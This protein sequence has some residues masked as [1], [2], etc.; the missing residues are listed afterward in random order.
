MKN[1][2]FGLLALLLISGA[3]FWYLSDQRT[4]AGAS[5]ET[6]GSYA[7][8]CA[9]G[10]SFL[11]TPSAD[12]QRIGI[13]PRGN[14]SFAAQTLRAESS[15]R[16]S[17]GSTVLSGAGE[18]VQLTLDG[19]LHICNP[20]PD[21]DNAPF[22]FGDAGEGGGVKQDVGLIVS[23]SIVAQWKSTEDP[24]FTREFTA[25]A[26][27]DRYDGNVVST[28][29]W[30]VFTKVQ[31]LDVAFPLLEDGVYLRLTMQGAQAEHVHFK[32]GKLT[33]ETL[34]LVYMDRGGTLTFSRV[35]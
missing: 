28:G 7:Y 33:P 35:Q 1:I 6:F 3:A 15:A 8:T 21:A 27:T 2:F 4:D 10:F 20:V 17:S 22:N 30:K 23:E 16:F 18:E 24:K 34:E 14:E 25:D 29:T 26:V 19:V 12:M 13:A 11:M 5:N 31:P 9:D 32:V